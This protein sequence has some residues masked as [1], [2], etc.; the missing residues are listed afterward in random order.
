VAIIDFAN[1][2]KASFTL[3]LFAKV[4]KRT[5]CVAGTEGIL[6]ADTA[7]ECI[8]IHY[9]NDKEY[10]KIEC[11]AD[12]D[13]GH[14]GSDQTFLDDFIDCVIN[15]RPSEVDYMAGLSS[16]VIGNA[17]EKARLTNTVVEIPA[18]AYQL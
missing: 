8:H 2:I 17:I 13:S 3:N 6:Y 10:E 14:G 9:S 1:G 4:P 5:I 11:K 18:E 15:S 12:N 7:E 16:T